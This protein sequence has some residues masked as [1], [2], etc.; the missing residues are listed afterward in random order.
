MNELKYSSKQGS[1]GHSGGKGC[2]G[3][4]SIPPGFTGDGILI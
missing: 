2:C 3:R 1:Q 4:G